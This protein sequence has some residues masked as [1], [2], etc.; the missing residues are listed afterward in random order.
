MESY[1]TKAENF[2]HEFKRENKEYEVNISTLRLTSHFSLHR[3]SRLIFHIS[4]HS[5]SFS[6]LI[7]CAML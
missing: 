7:M 4:D 5:R 1:A 3:I 6:D 2:E